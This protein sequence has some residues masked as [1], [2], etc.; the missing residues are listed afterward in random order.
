MTEKVAETTTE[1]VE[2]GLVEELSQTHIVKQERTR[3]FN[4]RF[5]WATDYNKEKFEESR[6]VAIPA[7][8]PYNAIY[9]HELLTQAD[10]THM[11][12]FNARSEEHTSE[13]Q[14]RGQLVCRLLLE[15]KQ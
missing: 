2:N 11:V 7:D 12:I 15:K 14:S 9:V 4:K 5:G 13:L 3:T 6:S 1:A 8:T 10:L